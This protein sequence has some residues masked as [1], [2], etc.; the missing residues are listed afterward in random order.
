LPCRYD[1][2]IEVR[3]YD[4][5]AFLDGYVSSL[6]V[7]LDFGFEKV[8]EPVV[9]LFFPCRIEPVDFINV[10][11]VKIGAGDLCLEVISVETFGLWWVRVRCLR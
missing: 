9:R 8:V 11:V 6:W 7:V 10:Q 1:T 4:T 2:G 3:A 5:C